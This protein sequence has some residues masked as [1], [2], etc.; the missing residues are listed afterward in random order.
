MGKNDIKGLEYV[1]DSRADRY[2]NNINSLGQDYFK[3]HIDRVPK[4]VQFVQSLT[5]PSISFPEINQP[6]RFIEIAH[7]GTSVEFSNLEVNFMLDEDMETYIELYRWF[8][9]M[10]SVEDASLVAANDE[11]FSDASLFILNSAKNP[12]LVM[13]FNRLFPVSIGGWEFSSTATSKEP[14]VA[15][16]TFAYTSFSIEKV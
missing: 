4:F 15:S 10:K 8:Q 2:A 3:F 11:Y 14:I 16:V 6:T 1:M 7:P 12:N 5:V 9:S 13:R